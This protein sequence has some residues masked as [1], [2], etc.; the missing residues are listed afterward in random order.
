MSDT[1]KTTEARRRATAKWKANN[2]DKVREYARN[3]RERDPEGVARINAR[4]RAKHRKRRYADTEAWRRRPESIEHVREYNQTRRARGKQIIDEAKHNLPCADC[5]QIFHPC[6]MDF[7][8]R[9]P[10]EK[11]GQI[12]NITTWSEDRIRAELAKCELLC[13]VCHRIRHHAPPMG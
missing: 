5:G 7:H 11:S 2:P 13:A 3:R 9:N 12:S 4:S 1:Y 6:A 8:H 10:A